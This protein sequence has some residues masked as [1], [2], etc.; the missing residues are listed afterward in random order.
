MELVLRPNFLLSQAVTGH[1]AFNIYLYRI[2][3]R[4]S[5]LCKSGTQ[6]QTPQHVFR[7][8]ELYG[9][10]RPTDWSNG[11]A[12]EELRQLPLRSSGKRK[13]RKRRLE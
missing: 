5:P 3:K 12:V 4:T 10:G 7:D 1:G 6:D 13:R 9:E 2:G 11:L 8:C